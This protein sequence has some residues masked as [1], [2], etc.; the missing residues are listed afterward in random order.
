MGAGLSGERLV[1][2]GSAAS[3]PASSPPK[4]QQR[5]VTAVIAVTAFVTLYSL[6]E[7]HSLSVAHARADGEE[8]AAAARQLA[9]S[10]KAQQLIVQQ[11]RAASVTLP[12]HTAAGEAHASAVRLDS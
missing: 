5:V 9:A 11:Q 12:T 4:M 10:E 2:R 7:L 3:Q 6:S 1:L 8:R